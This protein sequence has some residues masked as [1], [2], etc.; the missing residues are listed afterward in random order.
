MFQFGVCNPLRSNLSD[1]IRC[2]C[3]TSGAYGGRHLA[4]WMR[5][6]NNILFR[7]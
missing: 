4:L 2:L 3:G 7:S 1:N 5:F 6:D